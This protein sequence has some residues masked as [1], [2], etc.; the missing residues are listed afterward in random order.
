MKE[1]LQASLMKKLT[2]T[3][4]SDLTDV[5]VDQFLEQQYLEERD[6]AIEQG[7]EYAIRSKDQKFLDWILR[8]LKADDTVNLYEIE[9]FQIKETQ[10]WFILKD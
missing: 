10:I 5:D 6:R 9:S 2:Q 1:T 7:I 4:H 8:L 3:Y